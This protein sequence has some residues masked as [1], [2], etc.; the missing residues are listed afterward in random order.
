VNHSI[1]LHRGDD[2]A[3]QNLVL[4][5]RQGGGGG[6]D[7]V[8]LNALLGTLRRRR[9]LFLCV[10]LGIF[11]LGML[12]TLRSTPLFSATATVVMDT[13]RAQVVRASDQVVTGGDLGTAAIDTEAEVLTSNEMADRVAEA[14]K[15]NDDPMF[16][17]RREVEQPN[18]LQRL[19][20]R[21]AA[22][23]PRRAYD[24]QAQRDFV[25]ARLQRGL[26][27]ER[28]GSTYVLEI[29]YTSPDPEFSAR[30]ANAY[31]TEYAQSALLRKR[32]ETEKA[33][34]FLSQ[35]ISQLRA[36]ANADTQAVQRYRIANNLLSTSASQLTEQEVS[37]YNQ[38]VAG[39]SASAAQDRAR[40]ATARQQLRNGSKG[41]DV[42]EAL[43]S[44]VVS[45]L[46]T[47][48]ASLAAELANLTTRYGDRH[49]DVV[50]TR[51][52]LADLDSSIQTEINRVISNLAA[53]QNVSDA[54]L[55]SVR[56]SLGGARGTLQASNKALVGFQDLERKAAASQQQY[57]AYLARY[58]QVT[59]QEGTEA[60]DARVI[61]R[62]DP[63]SGAS[64]PNIPL[65]FFL[66]LVLGLG[67]GLGAAFI[68]ELSYR[69]LT[70]G[71][72][73]E[74][75][76][77]VP[78]LGSVPLLKS[79][80]KWKGDPLD[81][82]IKRPHSVFAESFRNLQTSVN[83]S[84]DAVV[85]VLVVTSALPREGKST[86]AAGLARTAAM[87]GQRVVLVDCDLRRRSVNRLVPQPPK[88]GLID[89]VR[90]DA[91]IEDALVQDEASG[92]WLLPL[93]S[94]R[95]APGDYFAGEPFKN[96]LDELRGQFTLIVLDTAPV[97]PIADTR[98]LA[99]MGD[100][101]IFVARWRKT[102]DDAIR[103]AL[104]LLPRGRV[105]LA[106]VAL[107]QV[108]VRRQTRFGYGDP[109]Y[110][111]SQYKEYYS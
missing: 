85:Q 63:P 50:R 9:T 54:Q 83:Y 47:Q 12:L 107:S 104:K 13:R 38:Q 14:L 66:S 36:Q 68:A 101:V 3:Q 97:L 60:P 76:L 67:A 48:R 73:V 81:V 110:Y 106:G 74:S 99:T 64:S 96:L 61:T 30:V 26:K 51:Q 10:A 102:A 4:A 92:A 93:N 77:G 34:A 65:S 79:V 6:E 55:A 28:S 72:D 111:Y 84:T 46:K 105:N 1:Q 95:V 80:M 88:A 18:W 19:L 52:Q 23:I 108:D 32:A 57:E 8:D 29:T 82:L 42:G 24:A 56:S 43:N 49:P 7:R 17:P 40:L 27:V 44:G 39:A 86:I 22:P 103:S 59:A 16:A 11:A 15:L 35:R 109:T 91:K 2:V 94:Q 5:G 33:V 25:N 70:T 75:R 58:S 69:G 90:G 98:V 31:A 45:S 41:D 87:D 62:A 71:E 78:Y 53:R 20:G 100:A 89:V 37:T 21:E